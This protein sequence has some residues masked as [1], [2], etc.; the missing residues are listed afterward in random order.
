MP[1]SCSPI[2]SNTEASLIAEFLA[3]E[4]TRTF[5]ASPPPAASTTASPPSSAA[6]SM[7]P[8]ASTRTSSLRQG[9]GQRTGAG[10]ARLR[11]AHRRPPRRARAGHHHRRSL[12]LL[13]HRPPQVHHRRHPRPRAIH[14]Q[15]GHRRLHRRPR[16]HLVDARKGVLTQSRRHAYIA[17]LLGIRH[18]W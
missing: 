11:P 2:E 8:R 7:T 10:P 14:P 15:H 3:E 5:C 16:H 12:P 6:S 1:T 4:R 18:I 9:E 13:L 17:S